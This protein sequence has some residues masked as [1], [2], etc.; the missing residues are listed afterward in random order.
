MICSGASRPFWTP[1]A[2]KS[3]AP[4]TMRRCAQA[5]DDAQMDETRGFDGFPC[6]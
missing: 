1:R 2:A 3:H 5:F 6:L 4:L